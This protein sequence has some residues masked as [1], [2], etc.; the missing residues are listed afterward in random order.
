MSTV[1][2]LIKFGIFPDETARHLRSDRFIRVGLAGVLEP[3]QMTVQVRGNSVRVRVEVDAILPAEVVVNLVRSEVSTVI[4]AAAYLEGCGWQLEVVAV[5]GVEP[6][7]DIV[8]TGYVP[9][10]RDGTRTG[11][12]TEDQLYLAMEKSVRVS[13]ALA[14]LR[15]AMREPWDSAFYCQRS[16]EM[17]RR[18]WEDT[19]SLSEKDAWAAMRADLKVTEAT[20]R[21]IS[22]HGNRQRHGDRR[23]VPSESQGQMLVVASEVITR[24]VYFLVDPSA[25]HGVSMTTVPEALR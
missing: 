23:S 20:I 18:H 4:D 14:D 3:L 13:D 19:G 2:Y 10:L 9:E 7:R 8:W 16:I 21:C 24:L 1:Q 15:R 6:V 25:L 5:K 12:A 22:P 17:V 11:M